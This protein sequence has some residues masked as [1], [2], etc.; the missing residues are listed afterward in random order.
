MDTKNV[1]A[2]VGR[3]AADP[4]LRYTKDGK[5]VTNFA[6]AVNRSVR[7]SNGKFEDVLD[8]FFDCEIWGG[9]A[10]ALAEKFKKGADVQLTGS[11]MQKKFKTKDGRTVSRIEIKVK[12]IAAV[13]QG[14][15][16]PKADQPAAA[17]GQ[18]APAAPE[19]KSEQEELVSA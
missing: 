8:G 5:P 4:E 18:P 12:S 15:K 16:K 17:E 2:L 13:I 10:L 9:E 11:L 14:P 3:L 7:K 6:V 1:V 19:E